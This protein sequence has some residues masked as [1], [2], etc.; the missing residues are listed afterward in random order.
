MIRRRDDRDPR[1][2][3][4]RAAEAHGVEAVEVV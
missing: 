2:L 3:V 4:R 1:A